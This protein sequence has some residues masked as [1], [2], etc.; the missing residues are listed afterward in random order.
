[1]A[2]ARSTDT[3]R[4]VRP[5][6]E[7]VRHPSRRSPR[8]SEPNRRAIEARET[9]LSKV[10]EEVPRH[11]FFP[12]GV[13]PHTA[14]DQPVPLGRGRSI[15]PVDVVS[16]MVR[17]LDLDGTERVLEIGGG[18]GYQAALLGRLAREVVSVEVDEELVRHASCVLGGLG[19][20]NVRLIHSDAYAGWTDAAP[21]Q[22]IVV[23]AAAPELPPALIDQLD[24]GGRLVIPL[25][26]AEA[27]LVERVRK[28][29][30]SLD[31]QTIGSCRL[32]VL[33]TPCKTPSSFPWTGPRRT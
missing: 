31:S 33:T 17:A 3:P 28:R 15:P 19:W 2:T 13:D 14:N 7:P 6:T 1:M 30:G 22:A 10:L 9:R 8:K 29:A 27:Q 20:P 5:D 25:G 24:L 18:S 4:V 16:M 21:Y 23:G 12:P 11:L 26:N 32:D